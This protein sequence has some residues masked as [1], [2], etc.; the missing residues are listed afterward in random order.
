MSIWTFLGGHEGYL[1]VALCTHAVVG[2]VLG[3]RLFGEPWAG[4]IGALLADIDLLFPATWGTLLVHRGITHSPFAGG[5]AT[6]FAAGISHSIAGAVGIGYA[7]Q[8]LIDVTTPQ[9]ILLAYPLS[10]ESI[11]VPIGGHSSLVTILIWIACFVVLW[12]NRLTTND[13]D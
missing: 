3:A 5:V 10:T 12:S 2:Y 9:G 7:S 11:S 4:M 1:V 6:V 8:L 13:N